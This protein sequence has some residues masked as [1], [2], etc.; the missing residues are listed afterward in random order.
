VQ[1]HDKVWVATRLD[2]ARHWIATHPPAGGYRPSRMPRALFVARFGD[3]FEHTPRLAEIVH[4][5]GLSEQ[6]DSVEGLHAAFMAALDTLSGDDK[7][8]L[9]RAHPELAGREAAAGTLT[10]ASTGEQARLRF[11]ALSRVEFARVAD[12]NQRYRDMFGFPLIVAL[13]LHKTRD[14]VIA[15]MERRVSNDREAEIDTA[16]GQ[17]GHIARGRLKGLLDPQAP[18]H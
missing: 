17:V 3:L 14:T 18:R 2:I 16:I 15:E 12:A 4:A 8:A 9:L 11:N 10:T 7:I 1:G 6:H 13:A 5:A